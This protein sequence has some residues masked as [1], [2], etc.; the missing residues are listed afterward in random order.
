MSKN[1][2]TLSRARLT[3]ALI[4]RMNIPDV[5]SV[6]QADDKL[7]CTLKLLIFQILVPKPTWTKHIRQLPAIFNFSW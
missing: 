4:V 2:I 3:R 7:P 1:S 6:E 5:K